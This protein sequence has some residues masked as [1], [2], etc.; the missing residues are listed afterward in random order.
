MRGFHRLAF[1]LLAAACAAVA[2]FA[3][4][5]HAQR[6]LEPIV[7]TMRFPDPASKTFTVEMT[8]PTDKRESV[9]LMMAIWSPGFY[10]M[11]NYADRV[12]SVRSAR[13]PT[14]PRST[15]RS[16]RR[17]AGRWRPAAGRPSRCPTP[18]PRRAAAI[19]SNG[20]TETSAVDHRAGHLHHARRDSAHRP[21]EVRLELPAGW[22]GSMT[23]L[24][25]VA[26]T[27][28]RITTSRPTTTSSPTRR[29]S[30]ASI[31]STTEFTV[32]GIK[33]YW[34]YLG[35]AEWDGAKVAGGA[36]A[37]HR[38]ARPLLGRP[39]LQEIRLPQHR[40]R[41]RRRIGRR[42]PELGR[43]HDRRRGAADAGSAIPQR[44]VH[45]PRVL[46]RDEREAPAAGR[47]RAVRLRARAG[48]D[49]PVGR[50][51]ADVVLRRSARR[52]VGPRHRRRTTWPSSRG[53][54]P[55]C[56]R[57]SRAASCRRSSSRRRRC[58]SAFPRTRRW[59]TTSRVRSSASCSTRTSVISRTARRAWTT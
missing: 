54:S 51:G 5:T 9:D 31:S 15:S 28:S 44:R 58:S 29:S 11:Q 39:A 19:S 30:P 46:P 10:G 4:S 45:Q 36:D 52:A 37:A 38:G 20:V 50:R 1:A 27:A 35:Q 13:A 53:T 25:A 43:D 7:Y 34:T 22:K 23:S 2:P 12:S 41:R 48:D 32:G 18:S 17:A 6:A 24:D 21:A 42:A 16:R 57:N 8:V 47:A 49:G 26:A 14:A 56:R 33:H 3:P 55:T 40:H 59:T